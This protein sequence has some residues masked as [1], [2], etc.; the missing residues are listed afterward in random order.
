[1]CH[2]ELHLQSEGPSLTVTGI[3]CLFCV[4]YPFV[5][6]FPPHGGFYTRVASIYGPVQILLHCDLSKVGQVAATV[7]WFW[8]GWS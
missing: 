8:L 3:K 1:M 5:V 6:F 2:T 7:S 4:Q